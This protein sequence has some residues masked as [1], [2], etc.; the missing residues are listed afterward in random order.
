SVPFLTSRIKS[1]VLKPWSYLATVFMTIASPVPS[2]RMET[3]SR[4]A[5]D[6]LLCCCLILG[7]F[8]GGTV[9]SLLTSV[10]ML[11]AI[12]CQL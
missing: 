3:K 2:S 5:R 12:I 6:L 10:L 1:F 11:G 7:R 4:S 8:A 9:D